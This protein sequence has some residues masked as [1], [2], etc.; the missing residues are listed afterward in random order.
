MRLPYFS[1]DDA[2]PGLREQF[3]RLPSLKLT[4]AI[5]HAQEI[6]L[7]NLRLGAALL[8]A[9]ELNPRFRELAILRVAALTGA[10]YE[11]TQHVVFGERAGLSPRQIEAIRRNDLGLVGFDERDRL[12]LDLTTDLI[13]HDTASA[14]AIEAMRVWF[15]SREIVELILVVGRWRM[16]AMLMNALDIEPEEAQPDAVLSWATEAQADERA[17]TGR[18]KSGS[19]S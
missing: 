10:R 4:R 12:V 1:F 14:E 6:V 7:P 2:E 16:L 17:H 13:K 19:D 3:E 5:A 11:W 8:T 9:T 18:A 15:S